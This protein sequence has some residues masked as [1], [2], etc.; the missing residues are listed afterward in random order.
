MP[1]LSDLAKETSFRRFYLRWLAACWVPA[2][3]VA[4]I[5]AAAWLPGNP[6]PYVAMNFVTPLELWL[7]ISLGQLYFMRRYSQHAGRWAVAIFFGGVIATLIWMI[8]SNINAGMPGALFALSVNAAR[9]LA[10][11][12]DSFIASTIGS[13]LAGLAGGLLPTICLVRGWDDRRRWLLL[14]GLT[15]V[16]AYTCLL[17][18]QKSLYGLHTTLVDRVDVP[19]YVTKAIVSM[20]PTHLMM[21]WLF[22]STVMGILLW[23]M[24]KSLA[25]R[26][27]SQVFD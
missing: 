26:Q 18:L 19:I 8:T 5:W 25:L 23:K 27:L 6:W 10:L 14:C 7:L 17:P 3:A 12:Y 20:M 21:S 22:S 24:R 13:V 4:T 15:S 9:W 1:I 2:F 11:P 16:V